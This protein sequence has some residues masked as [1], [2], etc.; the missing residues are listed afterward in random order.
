VN[1]KSHKMHFPANYEYPNA[2]YFA[3]YLQFDADA[4]LLEVFDQQTKQ[5]LGIYEPLTEQQANYAY[6]EGKWSFKQLLGHIVD[7]E[8]IFAYRALAISRGEAQSLPGFDENQ[9]MDQAGYENQSA[10]AVLV[11]YK[12]TRAATIALIQSF[13]LP[14]GNAMGLANGHKISTRALSWM[15]AGHEKHHYNV[16]QARYLPHF[17]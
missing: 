10:E 11:Q 4:N 9:Y 15:I 17:S 12:T 7:S 1:K 8:R 13:T 2:P 6:A 16:I 14:Q 3:E 5:M